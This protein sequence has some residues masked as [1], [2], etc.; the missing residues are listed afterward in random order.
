M[1][2]IESCSLSMTE[3]EDDRNFT[4]RQEEVWEEILAYLEWEVAVEKSYNNVTKILRD[5]R[6]S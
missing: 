6:N 5:E 2:D 3:Q 4:V 1:L